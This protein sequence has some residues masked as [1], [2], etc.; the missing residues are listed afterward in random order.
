MSSPESISSH[1]QQRIC[2]PSL[3]DSRGGLSVKHLSMAT[4]HLSAKTQAL[5]RSEREGAT[6]SIVDR[7]ELAPVVALGRLSQ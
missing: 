5:P 7:R 2:L 4:G 6:P 3:M 1:R